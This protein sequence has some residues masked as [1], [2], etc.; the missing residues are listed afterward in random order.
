MEEKELVSK[1]LE[2]YKASFNNDWRLAAQDVF[3]LATNAKTLWNSGS[4]EQ[5]MKILKSLCSNPKL[6]DV[7]IEF[8]LKKPY[9]T[10]SEMREKESWRSQGDL[11]PCILREREVS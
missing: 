2:Q 11:N 5:R 10:L 1:L 7:N 9:V 3:E 6:N 4:I 8:D